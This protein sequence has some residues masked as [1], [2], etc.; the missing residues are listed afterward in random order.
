MAS[1]ISVSRLPDPDLQITSIDYPTFG[2]PNESQTVSWAVHNTGLIEATGAWNDKVYWTIDGTL[3]NAQLLATVSHSGGLG[4]DA[5]YQAS[6][7]IAVPNLPVGSY[8][9]V[10]VTDAD[11]QV[12][13]GA[14]ESNNLYFDPQKSTR[15]EVPD[16]QVTSIDYPAVAQPN[17][18]KMVK[19]EVRNTSPTAARGNWNDNVYW[20]VDG[21]LNR[22]NFL[23]SV[24]HTG[25]LGVGAIYQA[26]ANVKLP[27][28][29]I[30]S[31][32]LIVLT[33]ADG[34]VA[35]G[36]GESN[37]LYFDPQ[38]SI[39]IQRPD[40][41]ITNLSDVPAT[42]QSGQDITVK[43]T[44]HNSGNG[45]TPVGWKERVYL[46]D[47]PGKLVNELLLGTVEN[48]NQ[49]GAKDSLERQLTVKVPLATN[50]QKYLVVLVDP[51]QVIKTEADYSNN[52]ASQGFLVELA[53]Y[54][55]LLTSNVALPQYTV[56]RDPA[57][58]TVS[59]TVTNQGTGVGITDNWVDRVILSKDGIVGNIDDVVI[60]NFKH[61]GA[62]GVGGSY[63]RIGLWTFLDLLHLKFTHSL[64]TGE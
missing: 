7:N 49:L 12:A 60:G 13:E 10:V 63:S 53:P 62:L 2:Q 57:Q 41:Q 28:L 58:I 59:W 4:I 21:T 23:A 42:L 40:L 32:R 24:T 3:S 14:G 43:W 22:D 25:G 36:V 46:S 56:I 39:L 6:A 31:Y 1:G 64:T 5:T 27:N 11:N 18:N 8:R 45:S 38:K 9:I 61:S 55:N 17:E 51:E 35:E 33:D 29:P 26:S 19:W 15:I 48:A 54:A 44:T 20:S 37:N 52:S 50:G 30:G 34:Q 47:A 16:L